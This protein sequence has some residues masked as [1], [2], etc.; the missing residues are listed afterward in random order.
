MTRARQRAAAL[1]IGL[2]CG[3]L[4][5]TAPA[6]A[7]EEISRLQVAAVVSADTTMAVTETIDYD[8]DMT[9]GHGIYRDIPMDE[10][11]ASGDQR[12][13]GI[14]VTSVRMD[15]QPV[16]FETGSE[17][18]FLR[19]RIGDPESFVTGIHQYTVAYTVSGALRP[20]GAAEAEAIGAQAGDAELYWDFIGNGWD[21][22]IA[23]ARATVDGPGEAIGLA[24]FAGAYGSD[25]ACTTRATGT[26]VAFGPVELPAGGSLTGAVAWSAAWFTA[27]VVQDIRMGP[28]ES[29]ARGARAGGAVGVAAAA[30]MVAVA[31]L[32]RR[33]D[34]GASLPLA[35]PTYGPPCGLAPA[36][37]LA[38]LEGTGST[39]TALMATFLDLAARGWVKVGVNDGG[40]V[41]LTREPAGTGELREWEAT[42][43]EV[44]FGDRSTA[45]LGE[46][47][48]DLGTRWTGI[49]MRLVDAAEADGFRNA[50][51]GRPD[52][53]WMWWGVVGGGTAVF[54]VVWLVLLGASAIPAAGAT[55][56]L[57]V[58]VGAVVA[59]VISPRTQTPTSARLLSEVAGLEKVLGTDAAAGRQ[60]FAQSSGLAPAALLATM[61]PYAVA[62]GLEDAWVAAFPDLRAEDVA[63]H[64]LGVVR[65]DLLGAMVAAGISSTSGTLI[66]PPSPS[67]SGSDASSASG[68]SGLS[69]GGFSGGGGGGGGGGSW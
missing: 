19:V 18:S 22:P 13:Y 51:G 1:A 41:F 39:P 52:R 4:L 6:A 59:T 49:G 69:G 62:L 26:T 25:A 9:V 30:L 55:I 16:T 40:R 48:P 63:A 37:M 68:G 11:L 60:R 67:S 3:V 32:W 21:V 61:L 54:S 43:V 12:H 5:L 24:C 50:D 15:G 53:R 28:G 14:E 29:A 57:G 46:Y 56:G 44:V 17:G 36:E 65:V 10:D 2:A 8:F 64:G 45:T 20:I 47:D 7:A 23:S 38:A 33:R 35:P 27:P 66:P 34:R 42:L 58:V 31:L